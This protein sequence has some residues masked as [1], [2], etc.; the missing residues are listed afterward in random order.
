MKNV[1]S[2]SLS[3]AQVEMTTRGAIKYS[4]VPSSRGGNM[5]WT[6]RLSAFSGRGM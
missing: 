3:K 1:S 4:P 5:E 2:S 6:K